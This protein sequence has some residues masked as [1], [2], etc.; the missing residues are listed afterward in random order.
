MI[1]VGIDAHKTRSTLVALDP[2]TG[3][4]D[5]TKVLTQRDELVDALEQVPEPFVVGV[6]ATLFSPA[7]TAWLTDA[8]FDV[9]LLDPQALLDC[10]TRKRAKTDRID[11][12]QM[13][14]AMADGHDVECYLAEEEVVQLRALTRGRETLVTTSTT[15]RNKLRSILFQNGIVVEL[16]DLRGKAARELVPE[17]IEQLPGNVALMAAQYWNLLGQV[18]EAVA[19]TD[20][21]IKEEVTQHPVASLAKHMPGLGPVTTLSIVAEIGR[22]DRFESY[23]QLHSYAGLVPTTHQ[24][25]DTQQPGHLPRE[26]NKRLR[27]ASV[28]AAQGAARCKPPNKA[29]STYERITRRCG[30]NTG[31]IAAAR[32]ILLDIYFLWRQV[33]G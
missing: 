2:S 3:E 30:P 33:I 8:G 27:W 22:I 12:T 29:R 19:T 28:M 1:Y 11:A 31:K 14:K 23:E 26:C 7:V 4:F 24:S 32:K 16:T 9:R 21:R 20:G 18:E 6:E 10:D 17:L 15:L 25:G 13:A 5:E